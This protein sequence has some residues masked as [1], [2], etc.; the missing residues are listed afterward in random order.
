MAWMLLLFPLL[1]TR[2]QK[3]QMFLNP[4]MGTQP[5]MVDLEFSVTPQSLS[6]GLLVSIYRKRATGP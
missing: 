6:C 5:S 1:L 4:L 2:K 3:A